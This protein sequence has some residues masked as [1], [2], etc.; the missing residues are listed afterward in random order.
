MQFVRGLDKQA[1]R[2]AANHLR[3]A[4]K[5]SVQTAGKKRHKE[6]LLRSSDFAIFA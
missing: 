4:P 1:Y 3:R 2:G 6:V 5:S